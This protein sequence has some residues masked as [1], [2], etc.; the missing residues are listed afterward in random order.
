MA[1]QACIGRRELG[2]ANSTTVVRENTTT[3]QD[4]GDVGRCVVDGGG[5]V[6][7]RR[8]PSLGRRGERPTS[9]IRAPGW[10]GIRV[11]C[12]HGHRNP[13]N[14]RPA[15]PC[16]RGREQ[17]SS[18]PAGPAYQH[19]HPQ[20]QPQPA[21]AARAQ[22]RCLAPRPGTHEARLCW[23]S[24]H[25]AAGALACAEAAG[26]LSRHFRCPQSPGWLRSARATLVLRSARYS[27]C[28]LPANA[29]TPAHRHA[30]VLC[31][32][33]ISYSGDEGHSSLAPLLACPHAVGRMPANTSCEKGRPPARQ[34]HPIFIHRRAGQAFRRGMLEA[35]GTAAPSA[36]SGTR[37]NLVDGRPAA[38]DLS[39]QR[40]PRCP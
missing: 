28:S 25:G 38:T 18:C 34:T 5:W 12:G 24:C 31:A 6:W 11:R 17:Q 39:L 36:P 9:A 3:I 1:C 37:A 33:S 14:G 10:L 30:A 2:R 27:S 32:L 13:R 8:R 20:P 40:E 15:R 35:C 21:R 4:G 22:R 16:A 29:S 19:M 7:V 26:P 23:P